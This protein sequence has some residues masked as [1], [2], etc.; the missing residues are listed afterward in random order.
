[1]EHKNCYSFPALPIQNS[2]FPAHF[3]LV[4]L[5][6]HPL[7]SVMPALIYA[8]SFRS[9]SPTKFLCSIH[10]TVATH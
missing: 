4:P 7:V 9:E 3:S 10:R 1:M 2:R 5:I 6:R 8:N